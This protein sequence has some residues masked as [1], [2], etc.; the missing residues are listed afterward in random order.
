MRAWQDRLTPLWARVSGGCQ[1]NRPID[2][3]IEETGFSPSTLDRGYASG[4]KP[5]AYLYK[6]VAV[7]RKS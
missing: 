4:P 2:T 6:G 3:L 7:T 1:L 5:M